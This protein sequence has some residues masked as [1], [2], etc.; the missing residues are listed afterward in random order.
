MLLLLEQAPRLLED[1]RG[2]QALAAEVDWL[3]KIE[4]TFSEKGEVCVNF[5]IVIGPKTYEAVLVFAELYPD[6]P[7]FVRPRDA[8]AR[9]SIHQYPS[10]GTVCLEWARWGSS[11][12]P[13][14]VA[15]TCPRQ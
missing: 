11:F 10:T 13:H 2:L 9:W 4:W 14:G 7:A 8:K 12:A 5:D 6:V 15:C 1:H 3:S